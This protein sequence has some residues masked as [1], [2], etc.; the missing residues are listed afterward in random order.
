LANI[1]S[2]S[3][4]KGPYQ[5]SQNTKQTDKVLLYINKYYPEYIYQILGAVMGQEFIDDLNVNGVP[6]EEKFLEIYEP[7]VFDD[8][9]GLHRSIGMKNVILGMVYAQIVR[10]SGNYNAVEG[11]K[12][13]LGENAEFVGITNKLTTMFNDSVSSAKEIQWYITVHNPNDQDYD[14]YNGQTLR[15]WINL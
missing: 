10:D 11:N 7:F 6:T 5:L 9:C 8:S 13:T 3:D 15:Y 2:H 14:D 12:R 4:F 1:I